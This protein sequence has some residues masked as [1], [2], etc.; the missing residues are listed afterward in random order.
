MSAYLI[1]TRD[2]TLDEQELANS[3][4][5]VAA[6][7]AGYDCKILALY[8]AHD[9]LEGE[10]TEG[11]VIAEF[12]SAEAAKAWYDSPAYAEV[13]NHRFKGA[14]YRVTLVQGV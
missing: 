5:S 12:P 3:H 10:P 8:G 11:T 2:K 4:T 9:D 14:I 6:T 1:F 7:I 13:R